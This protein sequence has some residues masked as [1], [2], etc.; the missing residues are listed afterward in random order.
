MNTLKLINKKLENYKKAKQQ[1]YNLGKNNPYFDIDDHLEDLARYD[2]IIEELEQIKADLKLLKRLKQQNQ[3]LKQQKEYLNKYA[4]SIEIL[5][6]NL[7][8]HVF[9]RENQNGNRYYLS[10]LNNSFEIDELEY[11]D[12]LEGLYGW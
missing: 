3:K 11:F 1:I 5:K 10:V 12:L 4:K 6:E 9:S 8:L 2:S 7:N